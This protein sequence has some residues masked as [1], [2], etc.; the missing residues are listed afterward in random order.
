M[1]TGL[2]YRPGWLTVR[3]A[4]HGTLRLQA[5]Q[6]GVGGPHAAEVRSSSRLREALRGGA[7]AVFAIF[8]K[9]RGR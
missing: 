7:D 6:A 8:G 4:T 5:Q 1:R 9:L 2:F 3:V